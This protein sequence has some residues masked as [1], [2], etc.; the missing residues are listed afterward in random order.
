MSHPSTTSNSP[1]LLSMSQAG[2]GHCLFSALDGRSGTH[3]QLWHI[4][5]VCAELCNTRPCP[6]PPVIAW[7][8]FRQQNLKLA[9]LYLSEI[10]LSLYPDRRKLLTFTVSSCTYLAPSAGNAAEIRS[11]APSIHSLGV[12]RWLHSSVA[13]CLEVGKICAPLLHWSSLKA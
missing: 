13:A 1:G 2:A 11:S 3:G 8:S 6:S 12:F 10:Q 4:Q 9:C 7:M 5:P